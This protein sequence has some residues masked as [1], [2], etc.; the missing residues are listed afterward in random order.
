MVAR[1]FESHLRLWSRDRSRLVVPM[2]IIFVCAYVMKIFFYPD[3]SSSEKAFC[4]S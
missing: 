2:A 1:G 4:F 3:I